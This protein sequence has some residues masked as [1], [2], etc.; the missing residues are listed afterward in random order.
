MTSRRLLTPDTKALLDAADYIEAHGLHKGSYREM[1]ALER[2]PRVCAIGAI[3]MATDD[4]GARSSAGIRLAEFIGLS[5]DHGIPD[6]NDAPERT[7]D[8]VIA[9][10]RGAALTSHNREGG[11]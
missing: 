11:K 10:L 2:M 6:W 1:G 9:A 7:A 8:E 3:V 5:K 4:G